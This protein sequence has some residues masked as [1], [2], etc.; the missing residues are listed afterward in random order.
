[1][2]KTQKVLSVVFILYLVSGYLAAQEVDY[3]GIW[4]NEEQ[5]F[6]LHLTGTRFA[7]FST[8]N[9]FEALGFLIPSND[10]FIFD[11]RELTFYSTPTDDSLTER[12]Q[13]MRI[14]ILAGDLTPMFLSALTTEASFLQNVIISRDV[15]RLIIE[16]PNEYSENIASYVFE[17]IE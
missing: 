7:V 3:E 5:R 1:M 14:S 12:I 17:R 4:F 2:N 15:N 11:T 8:E 6:Q 16:V 10:R 13:K 9:E